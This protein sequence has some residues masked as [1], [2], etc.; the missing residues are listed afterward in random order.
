M[1]R[2]RLV[3]INCVCSRI[4]VLHGENEKKLTADIG[5]HAGTRVNGLFGV[6]SSLESSNDTAEE[7][8]GMKCVT[9]A[10]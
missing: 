8:E 9:A 5:T 10:A 1:A 7:L 3:P 2:A 6:S 4:G